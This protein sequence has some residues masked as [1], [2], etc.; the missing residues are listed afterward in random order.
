MTHVLPGIDVLHA[1]NFAPLKGKRV[2]LMTNPS[3][4][5]SQLTS[6]YDIFRHAQ[7]VNLTA[8][9]G[10]EHGFMGAAREGEKVE[11]TMDVRTGPPTYSLYGET[12]RPTKQMLEGIDVL[13][14]DIQDI[15][16]RYYTFLWTISHILEAAGEFGVEVVILDRPNPIGGQVSGSPLSPE[17]ASLVGRFNIP[18][19]HGMTLGELA[20]MINARWN[21]TPAQMSV[22]PCEG[23]RRNMTWEETELPFVPPS[24]A[25]AHLVTA[26]HYP[27]ACLIEGTTLSE[28]RGTPLPFEV[29]G[30][31]YIDGITLAD[32]LNAQNWNGV[33]FRAHLFRPSTNKYKDEYCQGVQAHITDAANYE[34]ISTWLGVIREI[35]H[36][37]P[38]E[39][40]WLP[41]HHDGLQHFDILIGS[42]TIRT[43]IDKGKPLTELMM[44]WNEF[45]EEFKHERQ[46]YLLHK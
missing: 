36:L 27:G 2:G 34:P 5:D 15:G 23:W 32:H 26:R 25:M 37:Y 8:L 7:N 12:F 16:A 38:K 45:V 21:P 42:T 28:G 11:T 19:R 29:V 22:V 18:I 24:P 39:F 6:T 30:A 14:C 9:F 46:P 43:D 4:V 10:P 40:A 31:P 35:R 3:A 33:R 41:P 1:D 20:Q 13:V 17:C 44:G